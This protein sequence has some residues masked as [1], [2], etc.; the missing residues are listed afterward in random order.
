MVAEN[1][2]IVNNL[3]QLILDAENNYFDIGLFDKIVADGKLTTL[4]K[5]ELIKELYKIHSDYQLLLQQAQKY[6]R[7][8]R[9]NE[10]DV[11]G[12]FDTTTQTFPTVYSI[13]DRYSTSKVKEVYL[14]LMNY[15]ASYI[16]I[17]KNGYLESQNLEIDMTDPLLNPRALLMIV[18]F[19]CKSLKTITMRQHVYDKQSK[20]PCFIQAFIWVLII[21]I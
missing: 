6:I 11:N 9:D 15:I 19:L 17:L 16:K 4:E 2:K 7:S 5:L 12:P 8:E 13:T 21:I 1:I 3:D 14:T 10:T 20:T 18:A